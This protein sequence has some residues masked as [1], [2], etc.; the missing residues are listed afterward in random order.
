MSGPCPSGYGRKMDIRALL[1]RSTG[2]TTVRELAHGDAAAYAAGTADPDVRRFAHLPEPTYT[3]E[4]VVELIDTTIAEGIAAGTLAV[5]AVADAGTDRFLGSV[6]VFDVTGQS[7][8]VGFWLSPHGRGRG[9]A[10]DGLRLVA[11]VAR[12]AGLTALRARTMVDNA[13]SRRVLE[14]ARFRPAAPP[15][16]DTVPSGEQALVQRFVADL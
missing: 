6:V 16:R 4:R 13:G 8:E 9:A 7:A 10:A 11:E 15:E 3:E 1:P 14:R 12:D 2:T 5:L